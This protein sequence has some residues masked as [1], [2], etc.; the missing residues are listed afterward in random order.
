[1]QSGEST[2][3]FLRTLLT[4]TPSASHISDFRQQ[5]KTDSRAD[6]PD[7]FPG[8]DL[9]D[10]TLSPRKRRRQAYSQ[11]I[12]GLLEKT[13]ERLE[14]IRDVVKDEKQL[15]FQLRADES[16][17]EFGKVRDIDDEVSIFEFIDPDAHDGG[18]IQFTLS[19]E[20]DDAS[21]VTPISSTY[22]SSV[23]QK[24]FSSLLGAIGFNRVMASQ[25]IT[26]DAIAK[27][28]NMPEN[29]SDGNGFGGGIFATYLFNPVLDIWHSARKKFNFNLNGGGEVAN[30]AND[31]DGDE[32]SD[33]LQLTIVYASD[34]N[35]NEN[36]NIN[37]S[38]L[39]P[40]P[41]A[42]ESSYTS[43]DSQIENM[44]SSNNGNTKHDDTDAHKHN[45]TI[46]IGGVV[47]DANDAI[48]KDNNAATIRMHN[49][50][51]RNVPASEIERAAQAF[52]NAFFKYS[53]Y[54]PATTMPSS[55][56]HNV[57]TSV[58]AGTNMHGP[59]NKSTSVH[60]AVG[61]IDD[62][63]LLA[64]FLDDSR[65]N[66][67]IVPSGK[68][69]TNESTAST[70]TAAADADD[71]HHPNPKRQSVESAG[72]LILE[73]FGTV[74]GLTWGAF[75]HVQSYFNNNRNNETMTWA[76]FVRA[77]M[78]AQILSHENRKIPHTKIGEFVMILYKLWYEHIRNFGRT[79]QNNSYFGIFFHFW[80]FFYWIF[81]L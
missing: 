58:H 66:I 6:K 51:K 35:E 23:P 37:Q 8:F 62:N 54:M 19:N 20:N 60:N 68:S 53:N 77:G 28:S 81:I 7:T 40:Y 76:I 24:Y 18:P 72:I 70:A 12:R 46:D 65:S 38:L 69:K 71:R 25:P 11:L 39:V 30:E 32:N 26:A 33:E 4:T 44:P 45:I 29:G 1:M 61:G 49:N 75:S 52:Q 64:N 48:R 3:Q 43:D 42:V 80:L 55:L 79:K 50:N 74:I 13:R 9:E 36:D 21:H 63:G 34:G 59:S 78:W 5:R 17:N 67:Q 73:M 41:L 10:I 56:S 15:R 14:T 47:V 57:S 22:T 16:Q 27:S 2:N 31:T